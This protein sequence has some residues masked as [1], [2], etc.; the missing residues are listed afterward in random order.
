ML[1]GMRFIVLTFYITCNIFIT[2]ET[3]CQHRGVKKLVRLRLTNEFV[4]YFLIGVSLV[5]FIR[6]TDLF[7]LSSAYTHIHLAGWGMIALAGMIYHVFQTAG[8]TKLTQVH[9]QFLMIGIP[10]LCIDIIFS[11]LGQYE[12]GSLINWVGG[13]LI[14]FGVIFFVINAMNNV[15]VMARS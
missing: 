2:G 5:I 3:K 13:I 10:L 6:L 1:N 11:R 9:D 14:L 4:I 12:I 15:R 7:R 8:A